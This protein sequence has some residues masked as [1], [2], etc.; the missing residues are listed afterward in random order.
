MYHKKFNRLIAVSI[1]PIL[2]GLFLFAS[3]RL[4]AQ[5][6]PEHPKKEKVTEKKESTLSPEALA[7]EITQYAQKES[8][9]K[10]GYFLIY[11]EKSKKPLV[12]TLDHVHK[13][14]LSKVDG[15]LYF[16]CADFKGADGKAY[17]LDFFMREIDSGLDVTELTVHKVDGKPRYV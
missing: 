10:G 15:G 12:L 9:L 5:E 6:H 11:D 13:D 1:F 7:G 3:P 14:K 17:D 8:K 4:Q 16:A 2:S